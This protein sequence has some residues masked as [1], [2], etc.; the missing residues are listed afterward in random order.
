MLQT[1]ELRAVIET[2]YGVF[3]RYELRPKTDPCACHHTDADEQRLHRSPLHK[4]SQS[5]LHQYGMDAVYTWGTGDDFKH[6]IPRLFELLTLPDEHGN[7]FADA[8]AVFA[9]LTYESWCSTSWRSW[10]DAEQKAISDYF[11]ALWDAAVNSNPDDL[12]FDGVHGWIEAISQAEHDLTPYLDHWLNASSVNANRNLALM[13]TQEG[14]PNTKS[15]SGGY[16]AGHKEQ[17][18]QLNAWLRLPEVRQKLSDAVERWS[19]LPFATELMDAAVI[20]P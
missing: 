17:W 6:L 19:D 10:P 11:R 9:K 13:I 20:L 3:R 4:L 12:P 7:R 14:L 1:P 15:P 16:W 5:D 2:L 8:A 18:E